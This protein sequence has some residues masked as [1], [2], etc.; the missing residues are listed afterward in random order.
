MHSGYGYLS[1]DGRPK[2]PIDK[3]KIL[4]G[5]LEHGQ[6]ILKT[7]RWKSVLKVL[8]IVNTRPEDS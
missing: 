5:N 7:I 1:S 8:R 2:E 6:S 4:G 3:K